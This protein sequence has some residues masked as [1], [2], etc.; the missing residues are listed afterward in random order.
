VGDGDAAGAHLTDLIRNE[1][2][3]T[4]ENADGKRKLKL[5]GPGEAAAVGQQELLEKL[6]AEE[7]SDQTL[8]L[9][10]IRCQMCWRSI[11]DTP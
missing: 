6:A 11:K 3:G 1:S 10:V 5:K 7:S 8:A 9:V 4:C 2:K